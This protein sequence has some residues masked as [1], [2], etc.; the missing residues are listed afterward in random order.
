MCYNRAFFIDLLEKAVS[1]YHTVLAAEERLKKAGFEL[2][3]SKGKWKLRAGG[4]YYVA[5][6]GSSLFAFVLGQRFAGA[7][8]LR[9]A[10]AHTDFPCMVLKKSPDMENGG[11]QQL[12]I[13]VYGGPILNT[14][15]DRPLSAAGQVVLRSAN[16]W[17]PKVCYVDLKKPFC[18]I[19]NLALHMNREVNK[20]VALN[21]QTD[22]I[23]VAGLTGESKDQAGF[24]TYLADHMNRTMVPGNFASENTDAVIPI[25]PEDILDYSLYLYATERPELVG[26]REEL[27][28][29]CHLDDTTGVQAL[30]D[31]IIACREAA[32]MAD[33]F[34]CATASVEGIRM[35]AL[36][37]HEEIGSKTKQGAGS[38]L[39][40]TVLGKLASSESLLPEFWPQAPSVEALLEDAMLLSVDVAHGSHPNHMGKMDPTNHP[41]LGKGFCIKKA[42]SQ[43]YATDSTA[44][45]IVQQ[46]CDNK[47]IPW[48]VFMNRAD[49]PGGS[50][51][52]AVAAGFLPVLTV[53]MGVPVLAMHSARELM[54]EA[55][56]KA[57]SELLATFFVKD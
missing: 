24:M 34:N 37:D 23:P 33:C 57:M 19:P 17:E 8:K 13:E 51:L 6:G 20:G 41:I 44:I 18:V 21:R 30:L 28:S 31:G 9:M 47:Q 39:L 2:L 46:L 7:K 14:W 55:D 11:C 10:A 22:M 35:I 15:L 40:R 16:P 1:P 36:F 54:A 26:M 27:V 25:S 42:V 56:M 3:D 48:Q 52:G 32:D 50:T 43:S 49:E 38:M 4:A 29:A 12:N 53:D 45:A 5:P